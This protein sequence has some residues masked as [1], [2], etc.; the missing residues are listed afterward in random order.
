MSQSEPFT[1]VEATTDLAKDGYSDYVDIL[2][3]KAPSVD[4]QFSARLRKEHPELTLTKV[5]ANNLNLILF[6]RLGYAS[7]EIDLEHDT[8]ISMRGYVRPG[9][10]GE[11]SGLG[12][13]IQY[14]KYNYKFGDEYFLI[15]WVQIGYVP[16]QYVLKEPRGH[17][18]TPSTGSAVTD[19]LLKAAGDAIFAS[20]RQSGIWVYDRYWSK[21]IPLYNEVEK[22]TWDKVILDEKMK[23]S[24]TQVT[25][26]FFDS[27]KVYEDLGVPWKRGLLF[28]GPPGNGKTISIKGKT[29]LTS[30]IS[31]T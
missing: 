10:K 15:Y 16:V 27:K 28:H 7:A 2:S 8:A 4:V 21:S 24:L 25:E 17:D 13:A 23:E 22:A 5:P 14:A 12:E 26:K 31:L 9:P 3:A 6:A 19:R 20:D 29:S 1:F 11:P 18:E 30:I